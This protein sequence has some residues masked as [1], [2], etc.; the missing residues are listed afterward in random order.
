MNELTVGGCKITWWMRGQGPTVVFIQ[1]CG[2]QGSGRLPQIEA[3]SEKYTCIWFDNR[4]MGN[5]QPLI[6]NAK[7][8]PI[9]PPSCGRIISKAMPH[10]RYVEV[11]DASHAPP[12]THADQIKH[13]LEE[14]F[15][16]ASESGH[17]RELCCDLAPIVY[18][19]TTSRV[20]Y[21]SKVPGRP[22]EGFGGYASLAR[23]QSLQVLKIA[24]EGLP[25]EQRASDA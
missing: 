7:H 4:G 8:D 18:R 25:P 10:A 12:I 9:A 6:D 2:V 13:L 11:A 15:L 19:R 17:L 3:L 20:E 5:S 16:V 24:L 21:S 22:S 23:N 14:N 1:G